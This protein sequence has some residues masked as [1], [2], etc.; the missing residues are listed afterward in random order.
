VRKRWILKFKKGLY[1]IAPLESGERGA[2]DYSLHGQTIA[3]FLVNPYYIGYWSALS[4]HGFREQ[5]SP[6]IYVV[7]IKPRNFRR[8]LIL[9]SFL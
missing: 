5:I 3:S 9:G 2:G 1:A 4:H 7:T 8:Y 6:S